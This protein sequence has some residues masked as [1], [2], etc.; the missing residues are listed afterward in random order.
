MNTPLHFVFDIETIPQ[1]DADLELDDAEIKLGR[2]TDPA[3]IEAKRQEAKAKAVERAALSP[4]T[5]KIAAIG[6]LGPTKQDCIIYFGPEEDLIHT[7]FDYFYRDTSVPW[8]GFNIT[9]FDLPFIIRRAW[10]YGILPPPMFYSGR[11]L[12]GQFIDLAKI[13]KLYAWERELISL[14]RLGKFLGVGEKD[15]SGAAF[16]QMLYVSEELARDYLKRDLELIWDAADKMG[17]IVPEQQKKP[18]KSTPEQSGSI[19]DIWDE[20]Q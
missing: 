11:Y 7:F 6:V 18:V 9:E 4:L 12:P 8:V 16:A 15:G 13:W 1:P 17:V 3:K 14:N 2:L 20:E 10:H 19:A 5:G